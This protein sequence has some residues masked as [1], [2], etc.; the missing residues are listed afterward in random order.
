MGNGNVSGTIAVHDELARTVQESVD[1]ALA[2]ALASIRGR[3]DRGPNGD[4]EEI[5]YYGHA[6]DNVANEL[7][8]LSTGYSDASILGLREQIK[9]MHVST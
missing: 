8:K 4:A 5:K 2:N 3:Y 7:A 9:G 6:F 1:S